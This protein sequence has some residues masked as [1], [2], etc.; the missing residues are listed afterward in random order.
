MKR[1]DWWT[2]PSEEEVD[3]PRCQASGTV[4]DPI[5][6]GRKTCPRCGGHK[7]VLIQIVEGIEVAA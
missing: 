2:Y 7:R 1:I 6:G 5:K 3:C 4:K